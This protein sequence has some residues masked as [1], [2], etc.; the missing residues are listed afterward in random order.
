MQGSSSP[1][2]KGLPV[3]VTGRR[4]QLPGAQSQQRADSGSASAFAT[5]GSVGIDA[6]CAQELECE[7]SCQP[8][9]CAFAPPR[10]VGLLMREDCGA[11]AFARDAGA[12]GGDR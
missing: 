5:A 12:F 4:S 11:E 7:E 6:C 8:S 2:K 9:G 10:A 1:W 3:L